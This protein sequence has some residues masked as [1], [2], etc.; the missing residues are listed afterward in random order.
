[1][2][3]DDNNQ[4][5][6][7]NEYKRTYSH[8]QWE[9]RIREKRFTLPAIEKDAREQFAELGI[10]ERHVN[11]ICECA[12]QE[13]RT[14]PESEFKPAGQIPDSEVPKLLRDGYFAGRIETAL[15]HFTVLRISERRLASLNRRVWEGFRLDAEANLE[16]IR[17]VR[18]WLDEFQKR[19]VYVEREHSGSPQAADAHEG[20]AILEFTDHA[21][22]RMNRRG[23]SRENVEQIFEHKDFDKPRGKGEKSGHIRRG[24]MVKRPKLENLQKQRKLSKPDAERLNG[25]M[26]ICES[27]PN[28][29][30]RVITV[31]HKT[32]RH[33]N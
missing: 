22:E 32:Q 13:G 7:G 4:P 19:V 5:L 23:I 9:K 17:N 12:D 31:Q 2:S 30:F 15:T 14:L 26:V 27:L 20:G 25:V 11:L 29:R 6:N 24:W 33:R 8:E 16:K 21:L 28:D 18:V 3:D 10:D 1:M